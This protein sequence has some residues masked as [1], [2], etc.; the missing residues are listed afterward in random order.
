MRGQSNSARRALITIGTLA[1]VALVVIVATGGFVVEVG[2]IRL[3]ARSVRN[4][5]IIGGRRVGPAGAARPR[6]PGAH[7]ER[8]RAVP[9][10]PRHQHRHRDGG[11]VRRHRL[12]RSTP[13]PRTAPIPPATS[14]RRSCCSTGSLVRV[15]PLVKTF[16]WYGGGWNF[17]PLG[18]RPGVAEGDIVPTYP[19]GLPAIMALTR[20][21][22]GEFGAYAAVPLMGAALVLGCFLLG[23]RLHSRTAGLVAA[24]LVGHQPRAALFRRAPD[25]RRARGRVGGVGAGRRRW[26]TRWRSAIAA[27]MC[28]GMAAAT[29]PNLAPLAV[30]VAACAAGWPLRSW[31]QPRADARGARGG[32]PRPGARAAACC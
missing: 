30:A 13:S 12:R 10:P 26:A 2:S 27:G 3:T 8:G 23:R 22:F 6:G 20:A 5:L 21:A 32:G 15:E 19:L 14:A 24:A 18:Y 4:P 25:E 16:G 9:A 17:S 11:G 7:D 29:R 28:L 31:R 1:L